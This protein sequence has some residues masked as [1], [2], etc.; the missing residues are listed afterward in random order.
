VRAPDDVD[1]LSS[2][3][4]GVLVLGCSFWLDV[5][6]AHFLPELSPGGACGAEPAASAKVV[7]PI[8]SAILT[9]RCMAVAPFA[10]LSRCGH[11]E[12]CKPCASGK[13]HRPP[14]ARVTCRRHADES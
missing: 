9:T 7:M 4:R 5:G 12:G 11:D 13:R 8:V 3:F 2:V 10:K 14:S 6:C 1:R